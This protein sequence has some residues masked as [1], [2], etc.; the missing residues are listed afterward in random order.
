MVV[1][2]AIARALPNRLRTIVLVLMFF[3]FFSNSFF[4]FFAGWLFAPLHGVNAGFEKTFHIFFRSIFAIAEGVVFTGAPERLKCLNRSGKW[5][6]FRHTRFVMS[7]LM[8]SRA[9]QKLKKDWEVT[10]EAFEK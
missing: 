4:Y 1:K 5:F 9:S 7:D 10:P 2:N 6:R 3:I 8:E